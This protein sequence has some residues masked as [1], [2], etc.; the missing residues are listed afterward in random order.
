MSAVT[1]STT[2]TTTTS[3]APSTSS[4]TS[5]SSSSSSTSSTSAASAYA[6]KVGSDASA[7]AQHGKASV[8]ALGNRPTTMKCSGC[9]ADLAIPPSVWQ[10]TCTAGHTN[11]YG[12]SQCTQCHEPRGP[13]VSWPAMLCERCHTVTTVPGSE[14]ESTLKGTFASLRS[15]L[16]GFIDPPKLMHCECC[17]TTL[18]VPQGPWACQACTQVNADGATKCVRCSQLKGAQRVLCGHCHKATSVPESGLVDV[19]KSGLASVSRMANKGWMDLIGQANVQCPSCGNP[20][21]LPSQVH[22][23]PSSA[24]APAAVPTGAATASVANSALPPA[25]HGVPAQEWSM[26]LVCESCHHAFSMGKA[27]G[28]QSNAPQE[29]SGAEGLPNPQTVPGAAGA[30]GVDM[31]V[32]MVAPPDL[33]GAEA[34]VATGSTAK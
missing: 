29:W 15:G 21:K 20:V 6:S 12:S 11:V 10:W 5:S 30:K 4:S 28:A 18:V 25:P 9:A 1:S 16:H 26:K 22:P 14:I 13:S 33:Q 23:P 19:L 7:L 34:A 17:N 31:Q 27:G 24:A 8:M 2:T 3:T 32:A